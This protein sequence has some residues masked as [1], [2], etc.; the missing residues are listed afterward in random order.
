[1][2]LLKSKKN[3]EAKKVEKSKKTVEVTPVVE[4]KSTKKVEPAKKVVASKV[5]P[6][7]KAITKKEEVK[8]TVAKKEVAKKEPAKKVEPVKVETIKKVVVAKKTPEKVAPTAKAPVAKK[9]APKKE[10][11]K[12]VE[13]PKANPVK[14]AVSAKAEVPKKEVKAPTVK[15]GEPKK[16]VK[17]AAVKNA[18]ESKKTTP[19][20]K[21]SAK[22]TPAKESVKEPAKKDVE[23]KE[24]SVKTSMKEPAEKVIV[25]TASGEEVKKVDVSDG[26]DDEVAD[27]E[28]SKPEIELLLK[29][30][31]A[32]GSLKGVVDEDKIFIGFAEIGATADDI[33]KIRAEIAEAGI[34]IKPSAEEDKE[35]DVEKIIAAASVDDTVKSYLRDIGKH[36]LLT[37][38]EEL[39]IAKLVMEG[40]EDAKRR[41]N[42]ANLRLVVHIAKRYT[43]R[44]SLHFQDLIQEGNIGLMRAV[45]KFDYRKGFRFS[46]YA[47]WWIRQSITR[48]IADQ[49]RII[50]IPVHMVETINRLLKTTRLMSQELGREPTTQELA[51]AM[52]MTPEKIEEVR[53]IS[54]DTT[55][56]DSPLGEDG[57]GVIGDTI[58]DTTIIDPSTHAITK[59][60]K[61]QLLSVINSLTPREQKVIRLRYG[62][63]D[64]KPRTLE[65]VGR[66]FGVTRERIR[67]IE[68]KAL[69][70]LR[71]PMRMRR[72][73]DFMEE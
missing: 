53:R 63:D 40:D 12:K 4:V 18:A 7:K 8:K 10:P 60:L 34:F 72:L 16:V 21:V 58:A 25:P 1:M 61:E 46:T 30:V 38:E 19:V 56:I 28:F 47:T 39:E 41:L 23:T 42:Q 51:L 3:A 67:Q 65:E 17:V 64:G 5:E 14:K 6:A 20:E 36:P 31:I 2:G 55:S 27:G 43:G 70:K 15:V 37:S 57:D 26:G 66:I 62:I 48:A 54:Q 69:R 44:T 50:R 71:N 11:V 9:E 59:M 73:K 32:N 52:N 68:A 33:T 29:K 35:Q 13:T 24:T 22:E 49:S 45:E